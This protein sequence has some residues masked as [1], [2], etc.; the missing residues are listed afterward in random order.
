MG[1]I[2]LCGTLFNSCEFTNEEKEQEKKNNEIKFSIDQLL[3]REIFER[4]KMQKIIDREVKILKSSLI[5]D[6]ETIKNQCSHQ[7]DLLK[8]N[9]SKI[10]VDTTKTIDQ[11][12]NHIEEIK[13][14]HLNRI[15]SDVSGIKIMINNSQDD[16]KEMRGTIKEI[17]STVIKNSTQLEILRP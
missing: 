11:I 6:L 10:E 14:N 12:E 16:I 9:L 2:M 1:N 4:E 13:Y 5:Q 17:N 15:E 3:S 7:Q 8:L